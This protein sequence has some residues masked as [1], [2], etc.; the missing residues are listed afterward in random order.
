MADIDM[1]DG[2]FL[3]DNKAR[4][5]SFHIVAI[6]RTY[7]NYGYFIDAML[8]YKSTLSVKW[9]LILIVSW[10]D[11]YKE[12]SELKNLFQSGFI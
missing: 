1:G 4:I 7:P 6:D 12:L 9:I 2:N 11:K 5:G 8:W 3:N 10:T